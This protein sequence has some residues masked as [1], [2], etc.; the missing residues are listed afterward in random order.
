MKRALICGISGQDGT[1]LAKL[2]LDKGYIVFGTSRDASLSSFDNL[3]SLGIYSQVQL[4]SMLPSDFRSVMTALSISQPNEIYNLSGQSSVAFSFEQPAETM[5]SIV[6]G[7]LNLLESIRALGLACRFYSAGSA[8]CFGDNGVHKANEETPFNPKSPYSIAKAAAYWLVANYRDSYKLFACTGILFNH[9]SPLRPARFVTRKI[10][11]TAVEIAAGKHT[12][13]TLGNVSIARDWGWSPEYVEAM[14][15]MLQQ[16]APEDF[17]IAT[18]ETHSLEE[19]IQT[20]FTQ[21]GLNWK[22]HVVIDS[23]LFRPSEIMENYAD[24]QKAHTLLQWSAKRK[25]ADVISEM[26]AFEKG[27]IDQ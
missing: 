2:L 4:I 26:I 27:L 3:K 24:C 8:E 21:L 14:W 10:V 5:Y 12:K 18:G 11:K 9:E 23:A 20:T 1:Y 16:T 25:M 15:L 22:E 13:L 19:F 6:L 17:V 7:T